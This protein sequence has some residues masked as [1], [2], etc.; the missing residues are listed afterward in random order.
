M[1]T[2]DLLFYIPTAIMTILAAA[3]FALWRLG[4]S[5]SWL[6]AAGFSL[7]ASG[8]ALSS[9]PIEPTFDQFMS[10]FVF[11]GAAYC[12]GSAT[13]IHFKA[14]Q[15]RQVRL[16]LVTAFVI[17]HIYLVLIEPSLRADLFLIE[18]T[19][20]LLLGGVLVAVLKRA[21]NGADKFLLFATA[22]VVID[23][24]VRGIVFTF[25]YPTSVEMG[26]FLHSAYNVSVHVTTIT[27][28]LVFPLAAFSAMAFVALDDQRTAAARDPLTGLLN[29]RGFEAAVR[30]TTNA[31][32]PS[33]AV[34]LLDIDHFKRIN[35]SLGHA[36]GDEV[37]AE[38]SHRLKGLTERRVTIGRFGGE[39]FIVFLNGASEQDAS[40]WAETARRS[41]KDGWHIAGL[42]SA[43]T[44]SF[45]VCELGVSDTALE[46]G[47][48][49]AD[50]ALYVAKLSGRDRV[51]CASTLQL[52]DE[53]G[54]VVPFA[55]AEFLRH[56]ARS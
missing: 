25:I 28:C 26:D 45:G 20:A 56:T 42:T 14:G 50:K 15:L 51:V 8:F 19:F 55:G 34:V 47:I 35:D 39:E 37:I 30:G 31:T 43:V 5:S 46:T 23:C 44:A 12:Y 54:G 7:T 36:A 41:F 18:M 27:L 4:L 17:P 40:A 24:L 21:A 16:A 48:Q 2:Y 6:W 29:R 3:F 13:L 53:N 52:S 33:G 9:F 32:V 38:V 22:L 49:Q 11:I 1:N 10:G